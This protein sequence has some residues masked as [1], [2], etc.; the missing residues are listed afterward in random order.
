MNENLLQ[1]LHA[2]LA[3]ATKAT[4]A[5]GGKETDS[6]RPGF[7]EMDYREEE[8]YYR[9]SYTGFLKSWGQEVVWLNEK[10]FWTYLYGGG[11]SNN[12]MNAE[13]AHETFDFLKKALSS[14][15]KGASFQPRGPKEFI[16]G[17]W[18][19]GCK[20]HGNIESFHG[21]EHIQYKGE[22]AFHH[23]FFGGTVVSS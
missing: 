8:W 7:K 15:D 18:E 10:P 1:N 22:I 19:Y 13:F 14:G 2:F 9:D 5:G 20:T 6:W 3:R 17:T 16:D 23:R 12:Y 4:Y 21:V 11:M